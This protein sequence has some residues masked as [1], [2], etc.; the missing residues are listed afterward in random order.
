MYKEEVKKMVSAGIEL[1]NAGEI[2]AFRVVARG[3]GCN[4]VLQKKS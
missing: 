4:P 2:G 3:A 1:K